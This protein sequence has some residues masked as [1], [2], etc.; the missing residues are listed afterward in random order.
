V[1]AEAVASVRNALVAGYATF[2]PDLQYVLAN[3]QQIYAG[4]R[5]QWVNANGA[6]RLQM[7]QAFGQQLDALGLTVPSPRRG[8]SG[9]AWS[10]WEGKSHGDYAASMVQGLAG[11]SYK[12]A[13]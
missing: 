12:S 8:N 3:A 1:T 10:D 5:A 13:W 6:Q 9:S 7:A 11:S 2:P 4:L